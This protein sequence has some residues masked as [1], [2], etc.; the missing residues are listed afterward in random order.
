MED[1]KNQQDIT[2]L[3]NGEYKPTGIFPTAHEWKMLTFMADTFYKAGG[4]PKGVDTVP[5]LILVIQAGAELGLKPVQALSCIAPINGR[6]MVYGNMPFALAVK[7]GHKV[8][9]GRCDDTQ[10]EVTIERGDDGQK[11]SFTLTFEDAKKRGL[12][13]KSPTWQT[14]TARMLRY[15]AFRE[16]ASYLLADVFNGVAIGEDDTVMNEM[17]EQNK[18]DFKTVDTTST[19]NKTEPKQ[20]KKSATVVSAPGNGESNLWNQPKS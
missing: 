3:E 16:I 18:K 11:G 20:Q 13:G 2:P 1:E 17:I 5:K 15:A 7:H 6:P 9:W 14:H 4:L 10:A 12:A 8:I 19:F